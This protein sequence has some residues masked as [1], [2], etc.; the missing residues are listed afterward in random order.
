M[1]EMLQV[2]TLRI[3]Y[4]YFDFD[5]VFILTITSSG[6]MDPLLQ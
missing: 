4:K 5:I 6:M 2:M 3:G 1:V